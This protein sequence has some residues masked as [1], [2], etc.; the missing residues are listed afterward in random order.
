MAC[1]IT[2]FMRRLSGLFTAYTDVGISPKLAFSVLPL[3]AFN[4][5]EKLLTV[6]FYALKCTISTFL[7]VILNHS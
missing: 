7:W 5:L 2:A 3:L 4:A 1:L 6:Y